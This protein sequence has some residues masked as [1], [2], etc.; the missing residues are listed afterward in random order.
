MPTAVNCCVLAALSLLTLPASAHH[1]PA[2]FDLTADAMLE[3]TITEF[4]W[5]NPHV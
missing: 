3:G 5:R 4:S 2:Q 1:S